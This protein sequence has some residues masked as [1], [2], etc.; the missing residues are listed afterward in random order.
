LRTYVRVKP[1]RGTSRSE[2]ANRRTAKVR[3]AE[4][5]NLNAS[6]YSFSLPLPLPHK[7][8]HKLITVEHHIRHTIPISQRATRKRHRFWGFVPGPGVSFWHNILLFYCHKIPFQVISILVCPQKGYCMTY[9][10]RDL[11]LLEL[12]NCFRLFG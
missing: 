2:K 8:I 4:N 7:R 12:N 11:I 10:R 5:K 6:H 1:N 3:Q 9:S